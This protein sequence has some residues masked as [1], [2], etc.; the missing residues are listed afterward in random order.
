MSDDEDPLVIDGCCDG[1]KV[2]C[3]K[4]PASILLKASPVPLPCQIAPHLLTSARV[5]QVLLFGINVTTGCIAGCANA[6]PPSPRGG[7]S[8]ASLACLIPGT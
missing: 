1:V 6:R 3:A 2:L 4:A 5:P 7:Y 8:L